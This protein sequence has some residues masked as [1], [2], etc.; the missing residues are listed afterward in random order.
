MKNVSINN[1]RRAKKNPKAIILGI[2]VIIIIRGLM[3]IA[4]LQPYLSLNFDTVDQPINFTDTDS[5]GDYD[6]VEFCL[7]NEA[8]VFIK[9]ETVSIEVNT[10]NTD[11]DWTPITDMN[12][13]VELPYQIRGAIGTKK[14]HT[15]P[16]TCI[17]EAP[18]GAW[19]HYRINVTFRMQL[20][21][22]FEPTADDG[23]GYDPEKPIYETTMRTI[24]STVYEFSEAFI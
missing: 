16:I 11:V 23:E 8:K 14:I 13:S 4:L 5:D 15:L 12:T 7:I 6:K 19:T 22:A 10:V 20:E 1:K 2:G 17:F 18:A 9:V 3:A 24:I 21:G